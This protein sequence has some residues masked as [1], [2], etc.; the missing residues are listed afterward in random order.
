MYL[1]HN[2]EN[3]FKNQNKAHPS[4]NINSAAVFLRLETRW[5]NIYSNKGNDFVIFLQ[6]HKVYKINHFK[7]NKNNLKKSIFNLKKRI[8]FIL[9]LQFI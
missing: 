4:T 1:K 7:K 5:I 3:V 2:S 6:E 8:L 9:V